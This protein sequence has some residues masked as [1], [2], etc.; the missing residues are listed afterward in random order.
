M[1]KIILKFLEIVKKEYPELLIE[2]RVSGE[3]TEI[4]YYEEKKLLENENFQNKMGGY[5]KDIFEKNNFDNF[6]F[7]SVTKQKFYTLL[8][9]VRKK[10]TAENLCQKFESERIMGILRQDLY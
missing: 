1:E 2:G 9:E 6:Y 7:R 5:I 3:E 10:D 4:F 8:V